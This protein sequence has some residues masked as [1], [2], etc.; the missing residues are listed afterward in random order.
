MPG[1]VLWAKGRCATEGA[2]DSRAC[3]GKVS[4]CGKHQKGC[5]AMEWWATRG[6]GWLTGGPSGP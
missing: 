2:G 4:V 6:L 1:L 3:C 5:K